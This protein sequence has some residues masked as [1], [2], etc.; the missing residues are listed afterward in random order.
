MWSLLAAEQCSGSK[1]ELRAKNGKA[2]PKG[3]PSYS[4]V[5]LRLGCLLH[6]ARL[7]AVSADADVL[8]RAFHDRVHRTQVDVPPTP[9]HIVGVADLVSKLRAFAA[10]LADSCHFR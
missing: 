2:F 8:A 4:W 5:S 10:D 9:A 3:R 7:E 1:Q 6:L